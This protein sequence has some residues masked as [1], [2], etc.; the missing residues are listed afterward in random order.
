[1]EAATGI[2]FLVR[3]GSAVIGGLL[4]SAAALKLISGTEFTE[5][6]ARLVRVQAPSARLKWLVAAAIGVEGAVGAALLL[7]PTRLVLLVAWWF[8]LGLSATQL[9]A[10][11]RGAGPCACFGSSSEAQG[12]ALGPF[13]APA[14]LVCI[15][16]FLWLEPV[17]GLRL[18]LW[19][20]LL[21]AGA[22]LTC[23]LTLLILG[24][25]PRGIQRLKEPGG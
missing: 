8:C 12:A 17:A 4:I 15:S 21:L 10:W 9:A 23:S 2:G 14:L 5:W 18:V 1:M 7:Q 6:V 16:M 13:L 3:L 19:E 25:A 11:I 22:G 20:D 24:E